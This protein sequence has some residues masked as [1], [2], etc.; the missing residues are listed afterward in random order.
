MT[1][2]EFPTLPKADLPTTHA[3]G[4]D[5]Y[6]ESREGNRKGTSSKCK[7]VI[8]FSPRAEKIQTAKQLSAT[9]GHRL[10]LLP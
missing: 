1:I 10:I 6:P 2:Q 9:A 4:A 8:D 3:T 7:I 5:R